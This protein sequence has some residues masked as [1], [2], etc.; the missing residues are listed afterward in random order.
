MNNVIV[1]RPAVKRLGGRDFEVYKDVPVFSTSATFMGKPVTLGILKKIVNRMQSFGPSAVVIGHTDDDGDIEKPVVGYALNYRIKR[2]GNEYLLIC[3]IIMCERGIMEKY[4][5]R[6]IEL[7]ADY[8]ID[9]VCLLGS[10][11]PRV[12]LPTVVVRYSRHSGKKLRYRRDTMDDRAIVNEVLEALQHTKE[13]QFLSELLK[14]WQELQDNATVDSEDKAGKEPEAVEEG[15]ESNKHHEA[16]DE[17]ES[18]LNELA[19]EGTESESEQKEERKAQDKDEEHEEG[20]DVKDKDKEKHS[21]LHSAKIREEYSRVVEKYNKLHGE[22]NRLMRQYKRLERKDVLKSLLNAGYDL[23]LE[24]ELNDCEKMSDDEFKKHVKR[25][26]EHYRR[27]SPVPFD[28]QFI[29]SGADVQITK[30]MRDRAI[31]Y[32]WN[33]GVSFEEALKRVVSG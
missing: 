19:G 21:K 5:R 24:S 4:P 8:T 11:T 14:E 1:S 2:N 12:D 17:L 26:K 3:D 18:L 28:S 29:E 22:Y 9:P 15:D 31:E 13:W 27:K 10:S 16:N 6:S 30:E 33:H 32:A 23:D 25:I 7:W 20:A